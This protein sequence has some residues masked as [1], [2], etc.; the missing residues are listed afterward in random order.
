MSLPLMAI[1]NDGSDLLV[2]MRCDKC[3][4]LFQMKFVK[5]SLGTFDNKV[6]STEGWAKANEHVLTCFKEEHRCQ[7]K[8]SS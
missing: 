4:D 2:T 8:T 3:K 1:D 5:G 6:I 7:E